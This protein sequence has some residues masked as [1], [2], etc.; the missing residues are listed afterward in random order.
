LSSAWARLSPLDNLYLALLLAL[1]AVLAWRP[2]YGNLDFWALAAAGRW[3]WQNG[4]VPRHTLFLW[5]ASEPWVAHHWL[6]QV[7]FYGLT[8]LGGERNYPYAVLAFT[9]ALVALPF[10]LVWRL[11]GRRERLP[12]WLAV[13]FALGVEASS[14]RYQTRPELFTALFLTCLLA[15][16]VAW[17]GRGAG[18]PVRWRSAALVLAAL[19][20]AWANCHGAVVVGLL[21]LAVTAA[22]DLAQDRLDRRSRALALLALLAPLAVC[23]NPYG[24]AYWRALAPVSGYT[25]THIN[26]WKPLW[27]LDPPEPWKEI[28]LQGLLL[29]LAAA[30]WALNGRRRWCHLAWLLLLAALFAGA[31]RNIW[32]MALVSLTVLALNAAALEPGRLLEKVR[33]LRGRGPGRPLEVPAAVRW[34]VRAAVLCWL[35]LTV[36]T[37]ADAAPPARVVR[38]VHLEGGIVRFLKEPPPGRMFNDYENSS[39]LQWRFAG[40]PPLFIDLLNAYPDQ[41]TRDYHAIIQVTPRGRELLEEY[42]VGYVVLTA[43]R[44][45][46]KLARLAGYLDA[47]RRWRRA[48]AGR[49]GVVWVRHTPEYRYLW[50]N[51]E[52][53]AAAAAAGLA[54]PVGRPWNALAAVA[55]AETRGRT[56]PTAFGML[57]MLGG[58][59]EP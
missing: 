46:P 21:V 56:L 57:E 9:V 11:G 3:A 25:F 39:Y 15:F 4:Q 49:D 48:S 42:G 10:A 22:C 45:G 59:G 53:V 23:V 37:T 29:A 52:L 30:A 14:M 40:D 41:L 19:F 13:P 43:N 8:N 54:Q 5:T 36:Y 34:P 51:T 27:K 28:A 38:P 2:L 33:R 24:L 26:E 1:C 12:S 35:A 47:N 16:L 18:A 7:L 17:H 55:E 44:P 6:T 31:L 50:G 58:G 32:L 20:V